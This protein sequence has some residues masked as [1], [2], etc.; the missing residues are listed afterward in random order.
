MPFSFVLEEERGRWK[1]FRKGLSKEDQEAFDRL[2]DR[3]KMHTSAGFICRIPGH[4]KQFSSPSVWNMKKCS[5]KSLVSSRKGRRKPNE[6]VEKLLLLLRLEPVG[7]LLAI[8]G[9]LPTARLLMIR[10]TW[11]P[12][13]LWL[14]LR[15]CPCPRSSPDPACP[16][17]FL[18]NG[19][20]LA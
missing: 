5:A 15:F 1:E 8:R 10:L 12:C 6:S 3:A 20:A 19:K 4:W 7:D 16:G 11:V 14:R 18:S 2:F 9:A 13:P 17:P